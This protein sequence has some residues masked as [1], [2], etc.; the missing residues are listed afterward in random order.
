[1]ALEPGSI[2]ELIGEGGL[3]LNLK[4]L[5]AGNTIQDLNIKKDIWS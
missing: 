3:A 2:E 4:P 1:M 5:L